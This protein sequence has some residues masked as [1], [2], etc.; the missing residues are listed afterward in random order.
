MVA[1]SQDFE[2]DEGSQ[3]RPAWVGFWHLWR[4][5]IPR[6][7]IAGRLVWG[8]VWRGHDGRR[9]IYKKFFEYAG[10]QAD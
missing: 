8:R 10:E 7:S 9:W 5:V 6:R 2:H 3:S 1:G 4:V